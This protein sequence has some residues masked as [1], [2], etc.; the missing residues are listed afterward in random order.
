MLRTFLAVMA[1]FAVTVLLVLVTSALAGLAFGLPLTTAP[2]QPVVQP[3]AGYLAA[4]LL[5]AVVAAL[6]GGW[7]TARLAGR[8]PMLHAVV[9]AA[10]VLSLGVMG[11]RAPQPGQ[12][13]WYPWTLAII[14][15]VG[16]LAG[17]ALVR[18]RAV[19]TVLAS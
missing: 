6:A 12:P 19:S 9:L 5:S 13:T 10:I 4:N 11:A 17:A 15:P 2:G 8:H 3:G 1:G 14:G 7:T 16:V 18:R